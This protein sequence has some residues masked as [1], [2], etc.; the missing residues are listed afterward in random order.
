[1]YP[2]ELGLSGGV[3][4]CFEKWA[5]SPIGRQKEEMPYDH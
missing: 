2:P 5:L 3:L 1:M 4:M